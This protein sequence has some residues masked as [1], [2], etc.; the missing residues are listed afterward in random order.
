MES[1]RLPE[2]LAHAR[3]RAGIQV[4][5][6]HRAVLAVAMEGDQVSG[7]AVLQA[8]EQFAA[9][10]AVA[11]H[12]PHAHLQVFGVGLG[13]Q[14]D[15]PLGARSVDR[16]RL[17]KERVHALLDGIGEVGRAKA[18]RRRA[19]RDVAGP[20]AV[21]RL[22]IGVDA[23][24]APLLRHVGPLLELLAEAAPARGDR[25]WEEVGHG[26]ELDVR[27]WDSECV[28]DRAAP[29]PA[30]ADEREADLVTARRMDSGR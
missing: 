8:V 13:G 28:G 12:Q 15:D 30:A 16:D 20:E 4:E 14:L 26:D 22:L 29:P 9:G 24:E 7:L 2:E 10:L 18:D 27:A 17:F 1:L 23:H 6:L 5:R 11:A 3:G 21:D 19:D 25:F